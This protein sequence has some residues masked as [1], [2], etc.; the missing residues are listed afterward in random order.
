[1]Y[2]ATLNHFAADLGIPSDRIQRGLVLSALF[3]HLRVRAQVTHGVTDA[4]LD[5]DLRLPAECLELGRVEMHERRVAKP[6]S[7]ASGRAGIE[8]LSD[9]VPRRRCP[10][11]PGRS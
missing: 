9:R 4:L 1:M 2:N 7:L 3:Q 10:P 6:A 11:D 5:G 8:R